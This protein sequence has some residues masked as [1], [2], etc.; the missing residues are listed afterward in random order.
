MPELMVQQEA[1]L[2]LLI[3]IKWAHCV[4]IFEQVITIGF[5]LSI[6]ICNKTEIK[7]I[8]IH[9]VAFLFQGHL[10]RIC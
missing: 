8:Y 7:T 10:S 4:T 3:F 1:H 6:C 5:D 9:G 2:E